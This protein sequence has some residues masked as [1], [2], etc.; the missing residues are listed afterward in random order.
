MHLLM[1]C[2]SFSWDKDVF[3]ETPDKASFLCQVTLVSRRHASRVAS[4]TDVKSKADGVK[5]DS[6]VISDSVSSDKDV[7]SDDVTSDSDVISDEATEDSTSCKLIHHLS[8]GIC[9]KAGLQEYPTKKG[10]SLWWW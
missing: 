7:I 5:S 1:R 4:D 9:V 3:L 8:S 6:D 10:K 2:T